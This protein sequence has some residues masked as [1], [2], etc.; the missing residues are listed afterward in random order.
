MAPLYGILLENSSID[1]WCWSSLRVELWRVTPSVGGLLAEI[2]FHY[3]RGDPFALTSLACITAGCAI[4]ISWARFYLSSY[5][6]PIHLFSS[7]HL[8]FHCYCIE[9]QSDSINIF[10][11]F[12]LSFRDFAYIPKEADHILPQSL[13]LWYVLISLPE[14]HISE[15]WG[16]RYQI[17]PY[18]QH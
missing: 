8:C 14:M 13:I 4:S 2:L 7:T 15:V 1:W 16:W 17:L 9:H 18:V 11:I 10:L 5:L 12:R 6:S 3:I